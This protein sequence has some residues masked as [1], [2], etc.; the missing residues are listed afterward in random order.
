MLRRELKQSIRLNPDS[1]FLEVRR[2]SFRWVDDGEGVRTVRARAFSCDAS[3]GVVGEWG[4]ETQAV[5][6]KPNDELADCLRRQQ[7]QLNTI[8]KHLPSGPA[9]SNPNSRPSNPS[10]HYRFEADGRPICLRSDQAGHMARDCSTV[11]RQGQWVRSD[12]GQRAA[13][14]QSSGLQGN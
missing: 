5:A 7:T 8:L 4:A 14:V 12:S 9:S 2:E 13:D 10:R 6:A 11:R 1:Q 3:S